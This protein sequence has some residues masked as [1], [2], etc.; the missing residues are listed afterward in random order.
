[1][2]EQQPPSWFNGQTPDSKSAAY[3]KRKKKL[4]AEL[5]KL[6]EQHKHRD[7]A[8]QFYPYLLVR[9]VIGDR[10]DRPINTPFWESPDIW[11]AP[12]DPA[13]SPAVPAS[14]GGTL[15][16]GT[17]N[18]VYA[19]VWNLGFAPLAGISVE[20]YWFNPS[21]AIDGAHANLIGIARCELAGRGMAGSH[22]L[23][24]CPKPWV[25]VMENG[26]HECLVVRVSGIGDPIGNNAWAPWLNRHVAQRNVSVVAA[27]AN[28]EK[29]LSSLE[30]TLLIKGRLQLVQL[31]AKEGAIA[32]RM[33]APGKQIA[34]TVKT[35]VLAELTATR[36]VVAVQSPEPPPGVMAPVHSM[37]H[38]GAPA[39][40]EHVPVNTAPVVAP[41]RVLHNLAPVE[42][43]GGAEPAAPAAA[44][45]Q[46]TKLLTAVENLHPNVQTVGPALRA[47]VHVLRLA[48]YDA[49]GQLVGGYTLVLP[50]P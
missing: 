23:V 38:G 47:Q 16:V 18:T 46:L 12:G 41:Q 21:L 42:A 30:A 11:T 34:N 17:P 35:Q 22:L 36:D 14:H 48:N 39:P 5:P 33:V 2:S 45:P 43:A 6:L 20:Y 32:A 10:G 40:P 49:G 15:T 28:I 44:A 13:T 7:R 3:Q 31:G 1:M 4:L 25:P 27:Q 24:K 29:L 50:G 37:M 19:H 26:G 9:S 8:H